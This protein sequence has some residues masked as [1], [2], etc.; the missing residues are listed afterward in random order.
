MHMEQEHGDADSHLAPSSS[1]PDLMDAM[2]RT[3]MFSTP[4]FMG[5]P[6]HSG[7]M[8]GMS[9]DQDNA[10]RMGANMHQHTYFHTGDD[11][12]DD[13][14]GD[15]DGGAAFRTRGMMQVGGSSWA[16][17]GGRSGKADE[18]DEEGVRMPDPIRHE[19]MIGGMD[20][21]NPY[22]R[23]D[24]A[25]VTWLFPPPRQLSYAGAFQEVL[26]VSIIFKLCCPGRKIDIQ[27]K[28]FTVK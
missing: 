6:M 3:D 26:A 18:Y 19:R 27:L 25:D 28:E 17:N 16:G 1:A 4:N 15:Y 23:A 10:L 7:M 9:T 11:D 24:T 2:N 5:M 20:D 22:S 12:D 21:F 8:A 14:Y 13:Q